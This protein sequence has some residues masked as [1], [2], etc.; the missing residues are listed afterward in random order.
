[1]I[2]GAQYQVEAYPAVV[3]A[4]VYYTVPCYGTINGEFL[5][6]FGVYRLACDMVPLIAGITHNG[7]I[8]PGYWQVARATVVSCRVGT[9][10]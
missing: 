5:V 6:C 4:V 3:W 2:C 10:I 9:W 7:F 1:M 8:L